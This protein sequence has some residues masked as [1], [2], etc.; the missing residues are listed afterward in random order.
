MVRKRQP[1][2]VETFRDSVADAGFGDGWSLI[3]R[4][5]KVQ[6]Q[7]SWLE[8]G[9]NRRKSTAMLPIPWDKGQTKEV[10]EALELITGAMKEGKTLK[11]AAALY[12][13]R[14]TAG[15]EPGGGVDWDSAFELWKK[16]KLADAGGLISEE[17]G[18]YKND[19]NRWKWIRIAMQERPPENA[20]QIFEMATYSAKKDATGAW[21]KLPPGGAGRQKKVQTVNQFLS[22]CRD[23]LGF[24]VR[25]HPPRNYTKF[26][27]TKPK[28]ASTGVRQKHKKD[29]IPEWAIKPLMDAFPNTEFGRRWWLAIGLLACFGL[30]PWELKF[31]EVEG[32]FLRVTEGKKNQKQ[33]EPR[34]CVGLDPQGMPGLSQK[35]L[36]QLACGEPGLPP[37]GSHPDMTACRVNYYLEHMRDGYWMQLKKE[38]KARGEVLAAYSFRHRYADAL[39]SAGFNDRHSSQFMGNSRETFVKHYGNKAR[40]EELIAAASAVLKPKPAQVVSDIYAPV[41]KSLPSAS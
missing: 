27:G 14:D 5:D 28:A 31:L 32:E 7:H 11:E 40:E 23:E 38:A 39:D 3:E 4:N 21:I 8:P 1:K 33:A 18:F 30:R 36:V 9:G 34:L 15:S 12:A 24:D 2:W 22:Y 17:R 26:I 25:W 6:V 35:L 20:S 10:I 41:L 19:G 29:A 13:K 16:S 37:M